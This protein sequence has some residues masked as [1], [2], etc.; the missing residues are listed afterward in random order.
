MLVPVAVSAFFFTC[1]ILTKTKLNRAVT[2]VLFNFVSDV[3]LCFKSNKCCTDR[4]EMQVTKIFLSFFRH[5][6]FTGILV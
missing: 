5:L 1:C 6:L 2:N 3:I 4:P